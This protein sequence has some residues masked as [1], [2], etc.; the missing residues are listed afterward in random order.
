MDIGKKESHWIFAEY[1]LRGYY[2][3]LLIGLVFPLILVILS[4]SY[5]HNSH[6]SDQEGRRIQHSH[7]NACCACP[8]VS[9][10]FLH[11]RGAEKTSSGF[12]RSELRRWYSLASGAL[13]LM[14]IHPGLVGVL[15]KARDYCNVCWGGGTSCLV[16]RREH[17]LKL[18]KQ[19]NSFSRGT[20]GP[21]ITSM[22]CC[23]KW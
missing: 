16:Y 22:L 6:M 17:V 23:K 2:I 15:A 13:L 19:F 11:D 9:S 8:H 3:Y 12:I 1:I 18:I 7:V 10:I 4:H 5:I 20:Y 21:A 14:L